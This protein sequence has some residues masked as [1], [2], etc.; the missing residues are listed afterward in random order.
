[1]KRKFIVLCICLILLTSSIT[2][3][4]ELNNKLVGKVIILDSGHGGIG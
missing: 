1:M 2:Y 3:S 4:K